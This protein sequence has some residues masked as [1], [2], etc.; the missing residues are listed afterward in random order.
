MVDTNDSPIKRCSICDGYMRTIMI[1][2]GTPYIISVSTIDIGKD[3]CINCT[4]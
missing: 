2:N 4:K 1:I 3:T